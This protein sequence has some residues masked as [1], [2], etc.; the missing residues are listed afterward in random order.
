MVIDTGSDRTRFGRGVVMALIQRGGLGLMTFAVPVPGMPVSM[1]QRMFLRE[2]LDPTSVSDPMTL[3]RAILKVVVAIAPGVAAVAA[4]HGSHRNTVAARLKA[5]GAH[6]FAPGGADF[7][8]I[9]LREETE[10]ALE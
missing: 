2:D 8:Q 5:A 10:A 6:A 9:W 3:V 1:S 4:E 7:G